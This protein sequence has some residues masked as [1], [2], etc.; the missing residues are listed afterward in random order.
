MIQCHLVSKKYAN[1]V[2]L[3]DFSF[4]Q[5]AG[6][7]VGLLGV[8]GAG[9]S[10]LIKII[11]GLATP[12]H[13][14]VAVNAKTVGYMPEIAAM[15]E[16]VSPLTLL[17]FACSLRSQKKADAKMALE[18]M[19][20]ASEAWHKPIRQLSKGMRQR[21]G[22]AFALAGDPALLVFDEP[23][24]GLDAIG[25]LHFI[26]LLKKRNQQGTTILICS[27]IVPDLVRLSQRILL[28]NGGSIIDEFHIKKHDMGEVEVLEQALSQSMGGRS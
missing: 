9:K 14:T 5:H 12:N 7:I 28:M 21:V 3:H 18:E 8:N 16:T 11:L 23:M 27:H 15:P 6:E 24:T 22:L 13:G 17:G 10:T 26:E 20:L 19:G 1:K 2:A 25:R 4:Q